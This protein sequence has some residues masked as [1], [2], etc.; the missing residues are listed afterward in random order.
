MTLERDLRFELSDDLLAFEPLINAI[1]H[2]DLT[3]AY[4]GPVEIRQRDHS[5]TLLCEVA[6][7]G[8]EGT[9]VSNDPD[10]QFH[11]FIGGGRY[12]VAL[13]PEDYV[14]ASFEAW[15]LSNVRLTW[16][17]HDELGGHARAGFDGLTRGRSNPTAVFHAYVYHGLTFP[18]YPRSFPTDDER[19]GYTADGLVTTAFGR[20]LLIRKLT[21]RTD[22]EPFVV[23]GHRDAVFTPRQLT[24]IW[25]VLS[26]LSGR[27]APRVADL[28]LDA[29]GQEQF[30]SLNRT[31]VGGISGRPRPPIL[32]MGH[33]WAEVLSALPAMFTACHN[34]LDEDVP[35]EIVLEY[36]LGTESWIDQT[37]R[38]L[39]S[40]LDCLI[41]ADAF[42]P[43]KTR[44]VVDEEKYA[45][46]I[47]NL[48]PAV[49]A[50]IEERAL[51][52]EL[53]GRIEERLKGAND[54]LYAERCKKFWR[55]VGFE[56]GPNEKKALKTRHTLAHRGY[57]L[58]GNS[59]E[60]FDAIFAN[61]HVARNLVNRTI[62]ALLGYHGPLYDNRSGRNVP[63]EE[64]VGT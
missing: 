27:K 33:G 50:A 41:E 59:N 4:N 17:S 32:L 54:V 10:S 22:G 53:V 38:N 39:T 42:S 8:T 46:F 21:A 56:P 11:T 26:F 31:A 1:N 9:I 29:D 7:S 63:F 52:T 6:W 40:A 64:Q 16:F 30:R 37:L 19:R 25:L 36:L 18:S 60:E 55:R 3:L 62:L 35:L 51:P 34:L 14:M 44:I 28:E 5:A 24:A 12:G 49:K 61:T 58:R 2:L 48:M 43:T 23:V 47:S 20:P 13:R 57:V 15:A 45:A